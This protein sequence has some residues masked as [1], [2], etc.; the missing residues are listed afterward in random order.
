MLLFGV[1]FILYFLKLSSIYGFWGNLRRTDKD[2]HV[3]AKSYQKILR[4]WMKAKND[5]NF[6][7]E[8]KTNDIYPKFVRWKNIKNKTPKERNTYYSKNLNSAIN[9]RRKE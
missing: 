1:C 3:L 9:K 5:I 4:K 7:H 8:C 6:L 2:T